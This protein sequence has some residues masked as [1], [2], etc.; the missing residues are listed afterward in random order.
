MLPR[1]SLVVVVLL[2]RVTAAAA[3]TNVYESVNI[4]I[5]WIERGSVGHVGSSFLI[6][7]KH[8][9]YDVSF[10]LMPL[11]CHDHRSF[12]TIILK[13]FLSVYKFVSNNSNNKRQAL[14]TYQKPAPCRKQEAQMSLVWADRTAYIRRRLRV[15]EKT[16]SQSD[17]SLIHAMVTLLDRTLQSTLGYNTVIRRTQQCIQNCG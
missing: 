15:A 1:C 5:P 14:V 6:A 2:S 4:T 8:Y 17:Y 13:V 3:A 12:S 9:N 16:M 10:E 11:S 7:M